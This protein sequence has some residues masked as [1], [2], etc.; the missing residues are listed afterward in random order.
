MIG[1]MLSLAGALFI[2]TTAIAAG[3]QSEVTIGVKAY[4]SLFETQGASKKLP[5]VLVYSPRGECVGVTTG[6]KTAAT[7]LAGFVQASLKQNKKACD[8]VLSEEFGQNVVGRN[9]GTGKASIVYIGFAGDF[10]PACKDYRKQMLA[11]AASGLEVA[12]F[13]VDITTAH[14]P[15]VKSAKDCPT[16]GKK[17]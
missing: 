2:A 10:C 3:K 14:N 12:T 7:K 9:A 4:K 17:P 11:L 16:C 6:D 13:N 15:K 5:K 8:A 1:K